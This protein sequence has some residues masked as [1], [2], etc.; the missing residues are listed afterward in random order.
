[1]TCGGDCPGL[2][3]VIRAVVRHASHRGATVLGLE[4]GFRGMTENRTRELTLENTIDILDRGGSILGCSG[5]NP[6]HDD[7]TAHLAIDTARG[8]EID[9]LIVVGGNS[10]MGIAMAA[11]ERGLPVVGIPKTIDNDVAGTDFTVGFDT[12][13]QTATEAIDRLRTTAESHDRVMIVETMGRDVGWIA[14]SAGL[15]GGADIV[16]PPEKRIR[17]EDVSAAISA[18][19]KRGQPFTI[20][21]VGEGAMFEGDE[22]PIGRQRT[23]IEPFF[24]L[25]GVGQVLADRLLADHSSEYRVTVTVIGHL[26]RGGSPSSSDRILAIKFGVRA[27]DL[28]IDGPHGNMVAT[29]NDTIVLTPLSEVA[30]RIKAVDPELM[31]LAETFFR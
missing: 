29:V 2:N 7:E 9:C 21:V 4:D 17:V 10:S 31:K 20:I 19:R 25:G 8:H 14:I 1:M 23:G 6:F 30:G 5:Y 15:A 3:A 12:A 11:Q 22:R 28:A 18:D 16:L 27:V 13:V 26:Q 24:Q